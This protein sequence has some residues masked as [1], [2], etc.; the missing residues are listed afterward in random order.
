LGMVE[1]ASVIA[2]LPTM[3]APETH[4]QIGS[5]LFE[6]L[7]QIDLTGPYEVLAQIPNATCRIFAK[8]PE[9]V[10]DL[11]GLRLTQYLSFLGYAPEADWYANL[12]T[13]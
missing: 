1:G 11:H 8:G 13:I 5:L 7:D 12:L 4:L 10:R 2:R 3:I 9:P 6:G